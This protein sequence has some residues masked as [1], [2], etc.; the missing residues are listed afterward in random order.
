MVADHVTFFP[1]PCD[2]GCDDAIFVVV[3][4]VDVHDELD[5]KSAGVSDDFSLKMFDVVDSC[6]QWVVCLGGGGGV[7]LIGTAGF[8]GSAGLGVPGESGALSIVDTWG[9]EDD[10]PFASLKMPCKIFKIKQNLEK[11][12]IDMKK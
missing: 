8:G 3:V 6:G 10:S 7:G 4:I 2:E 9:D 12:E 1:S 11:N 5:D